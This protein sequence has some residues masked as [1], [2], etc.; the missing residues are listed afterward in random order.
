M[1]EQQQVC[2]RCGVVGAHC[3]ERSADSL[4]VCETCLEPEINKECH[5]EVELLMI[6]Y[7]LARVL[8]VL[9]KKVEAWA[10]VM[11]RKGQEVHAGH[12]AR[13]A[14]I[15]QE[16]S[17]DAEGPYAVMAKKTSEEGKKT[18]RQGGVF[19]PPP[20]S[21]CGLCGGLSHIG[22]TCTQAKKK[23]KETK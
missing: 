15:L 13:L 10:A 22:L 9:T 3:P 17:E 20:P 18:V 4:P 19:V 11:E 8:R 5:E 16:A 21:R 23:S 2:S 6:K 14:M 12:W 7:S 1:D